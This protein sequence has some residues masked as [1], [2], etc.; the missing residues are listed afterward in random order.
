MDVSGD[1]LSRI[2]VNPEVFGGKPTLKGHRVA[3]EHILGLL[4][5]GE[6]VDHIL[7]EYDFLKRADIQACLLYA[8][9]TLQ[10]EAVHTRLVQ[11]GP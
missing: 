8:H 3:V 5:A 4:A 11:T 2:E 6:S 9:R 1:L 7:L 10:G